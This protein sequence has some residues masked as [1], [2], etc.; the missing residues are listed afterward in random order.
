MIGPVGIRLDRFLERLP[1]AKRQYVC[2]ARE[3]ARPTGLALAPHFQTSH[4][5]RAAL[6]KTGIA[7]AI[8]A[9]LRREAL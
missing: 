6:Q 5:G 1:L 7:R 8:S 2:L 3:Y 4:Q 9:R